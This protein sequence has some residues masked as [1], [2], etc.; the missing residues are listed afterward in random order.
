MRQKRDSRGDHKTTNHQTLKN[1]ASANIGW[2]FAD[3]V[4]LL[5]EIYIFALDGTPNQIPADVH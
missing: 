3:A 4:A 5:F 2:F 1:Q